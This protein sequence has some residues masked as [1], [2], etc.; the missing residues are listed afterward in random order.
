MM[1]AWHFSVIC[2]LAIPIAVVQAQETG[3]P[4]QL[5]E[6]E[7]EICEVVSDVKQGIAEAV[8]EL[9]QYELPPLQRVRLELET[10]VDK[11]AGGKL[12]L[13]ILSL[14]SK[15]ASQAAQKL[16]LSLMPT[17]GNRGP[18]ASLC[19]LGNRAELADDFVDAVV[20]A[21]RGASASLAQRP[22][23]LPLP[24]SNLPKLELARLEAEIKFAVTSS[25]EGSTQFTIVP[26]TIDLGG[27][28]SQASTQRAVVEFARTQP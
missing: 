28:V 10:V 19:E 15:M 27:E 1:V 25:G 16:S 13:F 2:A 9:S 26:V 3:D 20:A 23:R 5:N 17:S 8:N 11:A 4:G 12:D 18:T 7:L 14:G 6:T 24:S 22:S 21:V